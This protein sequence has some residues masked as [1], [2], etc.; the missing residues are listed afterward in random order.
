M[1]IK[2]FLS[3]SGKWPSK[4]Q[5]G[6]LFK[7]LSRKEK[8]V[9]GALFVLFL[10]SLIFICSAFYLQNTNSVP[11]RGGTYVEGL[12]G[13][14]GFI[15]PIYANSDADRDLVQLIFSGLMKYDENMRVVPDLVEK[16][17]IEEDGRSYKFT[18]KKDLLWQD[19]YPL[20]SD[21]VIFTIKTIQNPEFKSPLQANWVGI[22]AEKISD[23]EFRLKL[24]KSYSAFLENCTL[25]ILPKHIWENIPSQSF[26]L[27]IYNLR[28]VG[29]GPYRLIDIEQKK[30]DYISSVTLS[31]SSNYFG[32][33][34]NI[35]K[36]KFLFLNDE[37]ELEKA[38]KSGKIMGW[39][40]N[41][42][43]ENN[44]WQNYYLRFPRYFAVF[45][46]SAK[47]SILADKEIRIA[48]N[49]ATDKN[50]IAG[51]VL[52]FGEENPLIVDSPVLPEVYG[53]PAPS[54]VYEYNIDRAKDILD[55][56]GFQDSDQDGV[57]E[58]VIKKE[59]AFQFKSNLKENSQGVEVGELQ[60]CLATFPDIY[61]GG[62]VTNY[63]GP[64]TKE[65]VIKF[66]EKY[67]EEIL[68]PSGFKNGNGVVGE[69][70]RK[71]LNQV[72]FKSSPETSLLSFSLITVDQPQLVKA[73]ETL[74]KQWEAV[75]VRI[76]IKKLSGTQIEQD[77]IKP[78]N[79]DLLLFGEI[80]GAIPDPLPFWHSS[81]KKDPGLNL[82]GYE[83]QK[84][85]E[86]LEA[87][88]K[89]SDEKTRNEKLAELQDILISD[90]PAVFLYSPPYIYSVSNEIKG[91]D[92]K[93]IADP[94]RRFTGIENW[95]IKTKR[96]W[97]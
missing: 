47:S 72:C 71:K 45:F 33:S 96:S 43:A 54:K 82:A 22:E 6:Q 93:E 2:N 46:N 27:S 62:E 15:N 60:K 70:T 5:W 85:D 31:L 44:N 88:R 74:K 7:V 9:F 87:I 80:L 78:R 19:K 94:S 91:I 32:K 76:E 68:E 23:W 39:S 63:F 83:N 81:Q 52:A 66:Q 58:K 41:N 21:D 61:P 59:P 55:K 84:A 26:H 36:I 89:T 67:A 64:K 53:L 24:K 35:T 40:N 11:S 90:A 18:L 34:P 8:I 37:K 16:Y 14:P 3:R 51:T 20:T 30:P 29:S 28:P 86:L 12:I 1:I 77:F 48:L 17:E 56:A 73:A 49:Y 38:A 13:Q 92:T 10:S 69:N 65:G 97:K 57:R 75:G 50:E 25:K 95:Y 79:Y 42:S 4:K